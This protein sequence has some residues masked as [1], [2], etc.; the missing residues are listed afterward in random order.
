MEA[1]ILLANAAEQGSDG[2]INALSLGWSVT[3]QTL[4]AFALILL[5]KVPW[6]Q[7]NSKHVAH[8]ELVDAD[9]R[10]VEGSP[11]VDGE[12]ETGRPPGLPPGTA[13]DQN[14]CI[15]VG[16]G[17]E[18]APGTYQW[19]FSIDGEDVAVESFLVR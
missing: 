13:I 14:L 9:G 17:M 19:R 12:F 16:G 2:L 6:D 15:N 18:L 10:Q 1:K 5:I 4:P 8:L 7:T 3:S 11:A